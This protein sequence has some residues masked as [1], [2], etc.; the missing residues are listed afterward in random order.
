MGGRERAG[1]WSRLHHQGRRRESCDPAVANRE[2]PALGRG[3]ERE[4][5]DPRAALRDLFGQPAGASRVVD[6]EAAAENR[7]RPAARREAPA[8]G[9]GVDPAREAG[10]HRDPGPCELGGE[11]RRHFD[12][13]GVR[14]P[15][16]HDR[17]GRTG[18][19][20][21]RR[22]KARRGEDRFREGR[23]DRGIDA[24]H[25][26]S[27]RAGELGRVDPRRRRERPRSGTPAR[28]ARRTPGDDRA[29][30]SGSWR[31]RRRRQDPLSLR[32]DAP[33]CGLV[34]RDAAPGRMRRARRVA[35]SSLRRRQS[36]RSLSDPA[37][38]WI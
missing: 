17:H 7:D 14:P 3:P 5:G 33:S 30:R 26:S 13:V 34:P 9:G 8:V 29:S 38:I 12:S 27:R 37:A 20:T 28:R 19:A 4:L 22:R 16:T 25:R 35:R 32:S 36:R 2:M 18:R 15:R 1:A 10:N 23:R 11:K 6:V 24:G 21:R 31:R